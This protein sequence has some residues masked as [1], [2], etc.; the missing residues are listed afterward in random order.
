[1]TKRIVATIVML[2]LV[3]A[4][5]GCS[6]GDLPKDVAAQIGDTVITIE[7]LEA[8]AAEI[9]AQNPDLVPDAKE[10]P[11]EYTKFVNDVLDYLVTLEV[12][13]Q[14]STALGVDITD[15]YL[16]TKLDEIKVM[17][18]GDEEAFNAALAEQNLTLDQLNSSLREREMLDAAVEAVTTDLVI[19]DEEIAAYYEEN[20]ALFSESETR[21]ARHMLFAPGDAVDPEAEFT[22]EEWQAAFAEAEAARKR[23]FDGEDFATV[24]R[25]VSEDLG[26]KEQGGDLG[27]VARGVMVPAFEESVFSMEAGEVSQPVKTQFGYHLIKV[28]SVNEERLLT[29]DEVRGKIQSTL[30]DEAKLVT[31]DEWLAAAKETA[32]VQVAEQYIKE[33]TTTTAAGATTT[34]AAGATPTT[35]GETTTTKQ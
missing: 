4:A 22:D 21:T 25:E 12:V 7:A 26:S 13:T 9:Q 23:L 30:L 19:A 16:Q 15:E 33:T 18:G 1:M 3:V 10:N 14:N 24:A 28:E 34:T 35:A 11:E 20:Q 27:Q 8:R 2:V 6:G 32:G 17:F 31:W 5:L 29:L